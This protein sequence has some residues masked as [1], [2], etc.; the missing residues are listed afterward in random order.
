MHSPLWTHLLRN[1]RTTGSLVPSS[2]CL[3]R[4]MAQSAVGA[5]RVLELGAG[6]GPVTS[7]LLAR[8]PR[9]H[10]RCV[11]LQPQMAAR[12]RHEHPGLDVVQ[13]CALE[14]LR[15]DLAQPG[16]AVVSSLPFRSLPEGFKSELLQELASFLARC[17]QSRVVQFTYQP[18]APFAA[19][20]G[21]R[22]ERGP[23]VLANLPPARV[24]VLQ[25]G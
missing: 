8:F 2:A 14:A 18:R 15:N 11:E 12:L 9:S 19:P 24:W 21:W 6:T 17:P 13:G 10:L 25:Q 16:T 20:A 4:A 1:P 5:S 7:A 23:L 22:W 3:A